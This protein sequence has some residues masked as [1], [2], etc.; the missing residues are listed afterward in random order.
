VSTSRNGK[1]Y[2]EGTNVTFSHWG[3]NMIKMAVSK[4]YLI[5]KPKFIIDDAKIMPFLN[6]SFNT[7]ID[8][9]GLGY[10]GEI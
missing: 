8:I 1:Y 10:V 2:Q 3:P 7:V 6:N 9:F 5:I 4:S